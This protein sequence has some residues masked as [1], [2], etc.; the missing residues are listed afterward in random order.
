MASGTGTVTT[1]HVYSGSTLLMDLTSSNAIQTRYL[2]GTSANEW[3][4]QD[5]SGNTYW[6]ETDRLG[7]VIG[8]TNSSGTMVDTITYDGFGNILSNSG[9]I[10][11]GNLLFQGMWFDPLLG[12]Y[13]TPNRDYRPTTGDWTTLDLLGFR[14]G[15]M[16]LYEAMGNSPTNAID[17][18]GRQ[19]IS[20]GLGFGKNDTGK[21]YRDPN[22]NL[23]VNTYFGFWYNSHYLLGKEGVSARFNDDANGNVTIRK[24][25]G[26][27]FRQIKYGSFGKPDPE[28]KVTPTTYE[29]R[30]AYLVQ[31]KVTS[32]YSSPG[33]L[34][35][36]GTSYYR[37]SRNSWWNW[38]YN[39][40]WNWSF[41]GSG[42][43]RADSRWW[44]KSRIWYRCWR[45][46]HCWDHHGGL[47]LGIRFCRLERRCCI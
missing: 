1:E 37:W 26:A 19:T 6:Y 29:G 25:P 21:I 14:A 47:F 41:W 3:L 46:W 7:S 40:R 23:Q 8:V 10:Y 35:V 20:N 28:S 33:F 9:P 18:S 13:V 34:P 17:P 16:N 5:S 42:N 39:W 22:G 27:F 24:N 38:R 36:V 45:R 43:R 44:C 30:Q 32:S 4:R 2:A 11:A 31:I 12:Q 15:S